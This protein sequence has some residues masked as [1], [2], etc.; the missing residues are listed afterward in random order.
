MNIIFFTLSLS[1]IAITNNLY[2][3]LAMPDN[4]Q[5]NQ[6]SNYGYHSGLTDNAGLFSFSYSSPLTEL[7][8]SPEKTIHTFAEQ[9]TI[10]NKVGLE[11]AKKENTTRRFHLEKLGDVDV[12]KCCRVGIVIANTN[13]IAQMYKVKINIPQFKTYGTVYYT[14]V[15]E[16]SEY[17]MSVAIKSHRHAR[18]N[19]PFFERMVK[20]IPT[21]I[22][23]FNNKKYLPNLDTCRLEYLNIRGRKGYDGKIPFA[24][25]SLLAIGRDDSGKKNKLVVKFTLKNGMWQ[26]R[27]STCSYP[28][29]CR[30]P[31]YDK[32]F[33]KLPKEVD[34][35]ICLLEK[36]AMK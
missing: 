27:V 14:P 13:K 23:N 9:K 21:A 12:I 17:W 29:L 22:L 36:S 18:H 15:S 20:E 8:N 19:R 1:I 5:Y 3:A 30:L 25:Y 24:H 4:Q 2:S 28:K 33:S 7:N 10:I 32:N 11:Q 16:K 31:Q 26:R 34:E 6:F 35:M